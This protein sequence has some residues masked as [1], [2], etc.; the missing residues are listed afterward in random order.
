MPFVNRAPLDLVFEA[1]DMTVAKSD[2]ASEHKL[3]GL[4]ICIQIAQRCGSRREDYQRTSS[5]AI[6]EWK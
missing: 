5:V 4:K 3:I 2:M 6:D 1:S